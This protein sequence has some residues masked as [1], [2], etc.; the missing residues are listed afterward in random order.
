LAV[1]LLAEGEAFAPL[2][3]FSGANPL[4]REAACPASAE[5]L[6]ACPRDVNRTSKRL[7]GI[8]ASLNRTFILIH[9]I[10]SPAPDC[11]VRAATAEPERAGR[12]IGDSDG[13]QPDH[14]RR[15]GIATSPEI[16]NPFDRKQAA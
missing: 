14:S 12:G 13:N 16:V 5:G 8:K 9:L 2:A 11:R 4:V 10:S 6:L 3:A 15:I 7:A 1:E